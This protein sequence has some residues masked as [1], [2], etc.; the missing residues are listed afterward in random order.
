MIRKNGV[1]KERRKKILNMVNDELFELLVCDLFK[2]I[3][4]TDCPEME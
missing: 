4:T 3:T 1:I 2:L